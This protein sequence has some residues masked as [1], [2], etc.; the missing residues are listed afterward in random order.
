MI[1]SDERYHNMLRANEAF[2][3]KIV[4]ARNVLKDIAQISKIHPRLGAKISLFLLPDRCEKNNKKAK[5]ALKELNGET[6]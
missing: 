6:Q 4:S 2:R 1:I 5:A 3:V